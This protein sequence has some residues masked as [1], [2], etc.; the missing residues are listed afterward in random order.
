[1]MY[2]KFFAKR[3]V[4][5]LQ[6]TNCRRQHFKELYGIEAKVIMNKALI[7]V[8]KKTVLNSGEFHQLNTKKKKLVYV[9]AVTA[10]RGIEQLVEAVSAMNNVRVFVLGR[11]I[12]SWGY[13]FLNRNKDEISLIP[14]VMRLPAGALNARRLW[15]FQLVRFHTMM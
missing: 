14:A 10:Q 12:D 5:V 7:P 13:N 6:T 2:E 11:P 9:G 8:Q 3:A 15:V 4:T 1:M